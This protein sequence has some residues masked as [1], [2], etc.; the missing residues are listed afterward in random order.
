MNATTSYWNLSGDEVL[1]ELKSSSEGL[2]TQQAHQRFE[3]VGQYQLVGRRKSSLQ[4]WLA[5]FNNPI[6]WLL[7]ASALLSFYFDDAVNAASF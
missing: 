3:E 2:S 7:F 1:A 6:I 5:Q 4:L